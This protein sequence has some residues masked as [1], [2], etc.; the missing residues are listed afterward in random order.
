MSYTK[1]QL[2][3]AALNE[4][5][6]ADYD[7]DVSPEETQSALQELDSMMAEWNAD[8]LLLS[9]PYSTDPLGTSLDDESN[10]P[11]YAN[12]AV[13]K[14]LAMRLAS[15][16]GKIVSDGTKRAAKDGMNTLYKTVAVAPQQQ[17]RQLPKGAGYKSEYPYGATPKQESILPVDES[18]DISGSPE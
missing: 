15:S 1:G 4:I 14:N 3:H 17:F 11:V 16:Y 7:F 12:S 9:Y 2:V 13:I 8:G 6:I 10:I 5:G 18:I